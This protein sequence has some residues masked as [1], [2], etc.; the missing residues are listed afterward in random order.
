[1]HLLRRILC[2]NFALLSVVC[3]SLALWLTGGMIQ[4][5]GTTLPISVWL[6][7]CVAPAEASLFAV[8]WWFIW[9]RKPSGRV[10]GIVASLVLILNA[11]FYYLRTSRPQL[12]LIVVGVAGVVAF[13]PRD[14]G[15]AVLPMDS[16]TTESLP[17]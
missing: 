5:H 17:D 12:V 14:P 2:W 10:W 16:E 4:R 6:L 3:F 11:V 8:A 13:F 15:K 1:M 7:N 9:K